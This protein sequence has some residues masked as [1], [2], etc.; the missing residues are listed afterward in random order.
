METGVEQSISEGSSGAGCMLIDDEGLG[1]VDSRSIGVLSWSLRKAS[2]R[3]F[4]SS[5][6]CCIAINTWFRLSVESDMVRPSKAEKANNL[7][8]TRDSEKKREEERGT[9]SRRIQE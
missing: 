6:S 3:L 8:Q 7:S 2:R 9:R 1:F 4:F 5:C